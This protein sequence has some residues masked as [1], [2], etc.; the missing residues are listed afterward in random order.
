MAEKPPSGDDADRGHAR[1]YAIS[2]GLLYSWRQQL[3]HAPVGPLKRSTPSFAQVEVSA[4]PPKPASSGCS[5]VEPVGAVSA[6]RR[7]RFEGLIEMHLAARRDAAGGC[8]GG[9]ACTA[10]GSWCI[11]EPMITL[12]PALRVYLACVVYRYAQ[13][14]HGVSGWQRPGTQSRH[15]AA[16]QAIL[17]C[18]ITTSVLN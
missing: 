6:A 17:L 15:S 2:S 4:E 9:W 10:A 18:I 8:S 12:A 16:W 11:G 5:A 13:I 7:P 3:L 14:T 1:K